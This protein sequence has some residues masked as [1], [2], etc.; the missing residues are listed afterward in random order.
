MATARNPQKSRKR[1]TAARPRKPH[2][3]RFDAFAYLMKRGDAL[4]DEVIERMP[5]DG[6][7]NFDHYLDGSPKQY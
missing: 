3:K 4:S 6:A 2:K 1:A 7:Q 5:E